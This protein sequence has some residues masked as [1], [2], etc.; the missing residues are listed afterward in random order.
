MRSAESSCLP[1][2]TS[3]RTPIHRRARRST[4]LAFLAAGALL[5]A[6]AHDAPTETRPATLAGAAKGW[7]LVVLSVDTIR[8]DHLNSYGYTVRETTPHID[9]LL[10]EGI[11]FENAMAPRSITWPSLATMLT[12]L[13]PSGHGIIENGYGFPDDLETLPK[14]LHAAGYS[15]TAILSNMCQANHQ[16]WDSFQCSQ[17][18][19]GKTVDWAAEWSQGVDRTRPFFLWVHLFGAHSPYYNGGDL[20]ERELDP[21]YAG[22]L[23]AKKWRLDAVM[24][25]RQVLDEADLYRMGA[26][27]DAA[28][29]GSD[30]LVGR[31]VDDLKKKGL[32]EHTLLVFLSDHGEELYQHNGYLYHACSV[33]Q[34][35]LHVPMGFVAPGLWSGG[36]VEQA[37]E[38][39]DVTPTILDLLGVPP[40]PRFHGVS[41]RPYLE[42]P[43]RG[44]EGKPAYSEYGDT[45]I[46]T[47]LSGRWK[48]VWNPDVL[49]PVC[50]ASGP[51]DLYPIEEVE[52]YDLASDPLEETNLAAGEPARVAD[53]EALIRK[54]FAELDTR[55]ERQDLP[56]ELKKELRSLGYVAN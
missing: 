49:T 10:A 21:E 7:N 18:R 48:L 19:D 35:T 45:R 26:I 23:E 12:G 11:R 13:Y 33:Y 17:G 52:L 24:E 29:I 5:A 32:L 44:G 43:D 9:A 50:F 25:E 3:P 8:A 37:I 16:G 4:S 2:P 20:A 27:Y 30:R 39:V 47:V 41:V 14:A 15:T 56:E 40:L 42:R 1:R 6:C 36:E 22:T 38:M 54:R 51:P 28:V 46:H 31:I 55:V 34:S 53:L